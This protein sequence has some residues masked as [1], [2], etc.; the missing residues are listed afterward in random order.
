MSSNFRVTIGVRLPAVFGLNSEF[1]AEIVAHGAGR[2]VLYTQGFSRDFTLSSRTGI[3]LN[4]RQGL[5]REHINRESVGSTG[6]IQGIRDDFTFRTYEVL[7]RVQVK[8]NEA[9]NRRVMEHQ[10]GAELSHRINQNLAATLRVN[11]STQSARQGDELRRVFSDA[12]DQQIYARLDNSITGLERQNRVSVSVG[13]TAT[14]GAPEITPR[15]PRPQRVSRPN[16]RQTQPASCPHMQSRPWDRNHPFNHPA[17]N[18][19]NSRN[20]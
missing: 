10:V 11:A 3:R 19:I 5:G 9:V 7:E 8:T 12:H 16:V 14:L 20:R 4:L 13:L 17:R 15:A 18:N 1:G 2:R 6:E